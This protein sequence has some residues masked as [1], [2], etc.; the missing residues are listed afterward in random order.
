MWVELGLQEHSRRDSDAMNLCY[1]TADYDEAAEK[2]SARGIKLSLISYS[3]FRV[4]QK[5]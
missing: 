3:D 4:R 5:I 1:T 2:L